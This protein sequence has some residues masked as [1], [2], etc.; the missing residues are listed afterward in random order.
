MTR[1]VFLRLAVFVVCGS[2]VAAETPVHLFILSGQ[3]NMVRLDPARDFLPEAR[4][5]LP[6]AGVAH[7]K[8]AQGGRPI[9]LWLPAW[10]GMAEKA[11]LDVETARKRDKEKPGYY[12][13]QILEKTRA[14][15]KDHPNPA[16]VSFCWMQGERDA[17]GGFAPVYAEALRML[18]ANLRRDLERPDMV[19]VIGRL[20]D[21]GMEL[22]GWR[23]V[24]KA[25]MEVAEDDPRAAW[26][27][28]DD[29][30]D[31]VKKGEPVDDLHYSKE[32]YTRFGKRLAEKAVELAHAGGGKQQNPE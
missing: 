17:R 2:A 20:S 32:G 3:S 1:T 23:Q 31:L 12:Y 22:P 6:D 21:W 8:V 19:V 27:N 26:V 7:I 11:G 9:R 18:I 28:T 30:N 25:Q 10:Y 4:R 16:S 14:V 15:L 13:E 5:L 29:C 24:R